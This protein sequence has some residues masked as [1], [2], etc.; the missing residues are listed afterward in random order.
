MKQRISKS[1]IP[2]F[3]FSG[4]PYLPGA[5]L[6]C[7]LTRTQSMEMWQ[8]QVSVTADAFATDSTRGFI[9]LSVRHKRLLCGSWRT[10]NQAS[11]ADARTLFLS[12]CA[13]CA[14][15]HFTTHLKHHSWLDHHAPTKAHALMLIQE[16]SSVFTAA[17]SCGLSHHWRTSHRW[18]TWGCSHLFVCHYN[19][20]ELGDPDG[21]VTV[22]E[23][24]AVSV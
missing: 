6:R 12:L 16:P 13:P 21:L 15:L 2:P 7:Q 19:W 17:E 10:L 14:N 5:S 3:S 8:F 18:M 9:S 23:A 1:G 20:M 11:S 24:V 4:L 22:D